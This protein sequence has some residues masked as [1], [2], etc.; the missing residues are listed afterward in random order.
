MFENYFGDG[1]RFGVE[2]DYVVEDTPLG[3]GGGI[4]NVAPALRGDTQ[5]IF[6][7]DNLI[8]VDLQRSARDAPAQ[9]ARTSR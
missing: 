7:G 6:N 2:L 8:T 9:L 3:T 5:L 1:S 4:R